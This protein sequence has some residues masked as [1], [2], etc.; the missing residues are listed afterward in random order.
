[1]LISQSQIICKFSWHFKFINRLRM[2]SFFEGGRTIYSITSRFYLLATTI[3]LL[4]N[5][6]L[7]HYEV[8]V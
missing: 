6:Q 3:E 8:E 5:Q 7:D 4:T 1:M 2:I